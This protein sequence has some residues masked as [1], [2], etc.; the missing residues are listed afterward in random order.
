[1]ETNIDQLLEEIGG[2]EYTVKQMRKDVID[3]LVRNS[4]IKTMRGIV[5]R[6]TLDEA[7]HLVYVEAH[8]HYAQWA[9]TEQCITLGQWFVTNS[10]SS[11]VWC[12]LR[13]AVKKRIQTE[14]DHHEEEEYH[15]HCK[16]DWIM[17]GADQWDDEEDAV[18]YKY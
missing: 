16:M 14:I 1:M 13:N 6:F 10:V 5:Q 7:R 17:Y 15:E 2:T 9:S 4:D 11:E 12:D 3:N 8:N 18:G